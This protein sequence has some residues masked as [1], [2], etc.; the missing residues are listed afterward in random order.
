MLNRKKSFGTRKGNPKKKIE[1]LIN[2]TTK[3]LG[4]SVIS[5][6]SL[7]T[8]YIYTFVAF[9]LPIK[10]VIVDVSFC[11]FRFSQIFSNKF[12]YI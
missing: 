5:H 9:W 4:K 2:M 10:S 7:Y 6:C 1:M 11:S 3:F 12:V 8:A